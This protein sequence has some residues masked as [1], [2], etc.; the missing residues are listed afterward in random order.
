MGLFLL[1]YPFIFISLKKEN[2]KFFAHR[3]NFYWCNTFCFLAGIKIE[4]NR[5]FTPNP[6][7]T[8]IFCDSQ[9]IGNYKNFK[10]QDL[11]DSGN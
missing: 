9:R 2:W 3:M 1:L 5:E 11:Y 10:F 6:L 7:E 8:Y 4:I